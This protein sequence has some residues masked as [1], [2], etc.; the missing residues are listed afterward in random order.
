MYEPEL[1][2]QIKSDAS[3]T[4]VGASLKQQHRNVWHLVEYFSKRLNNTEL[5]YSAIEYKILGCILAIEPYYP[6]LVGRAFN[7]L[8]Y[9]MPN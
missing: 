9:H 6:Y 5:R 3:A 1:S 2:V 4:V 8:T 7:V